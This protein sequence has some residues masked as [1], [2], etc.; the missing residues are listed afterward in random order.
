MDAAEV[1]V[2]AKGFSS[3]SIE[4]LIAAVGISKSGFFYHFVESDLGRW[5]TTTSVT[6]LSRFCEAGIY[7]ARSI[8]LI[9]RTPWLADT[10]E[11]HE[12]PQV[13]ATDRAE[14]PHRIP[15]RHDSV[16]VH[17]R[18]QCQRLFRFFLE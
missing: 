13:A 11:R 3:T 18:R 7:S 10:V 4:E 8:A 16:G 5:G 15:N 14:I 9:Q 12:L 2:L 6:A 1:A 17:P